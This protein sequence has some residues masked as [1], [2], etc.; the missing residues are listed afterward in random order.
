MLRVFL[1]AV[2]INLVIASIPAAAQ[3]FTGSCRAWC[4]KARCGVGSGNPIECMRYC[5][6]S[7]KEKNPKAKD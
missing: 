7:C 6:A 2:V 5:T 4:Q 3:N 1:M